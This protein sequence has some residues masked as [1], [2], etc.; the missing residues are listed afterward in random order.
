MERYECKGKWLKGQPIT[1]TI[2]DPKRERILIQCASGD[3]TVLDSK[4]N[5][6]NKIYQPSEETMLTAAAN[7]GHT[8]L[9][10]KILSRGA[11]VTP[12]QVSKLNRNAGDHKIRNTLRLVPM[13][14]GE[15]NQ[16]C[17][18][19]SP[20]TVK[21]LVQTNSGLV[22]K[23][24]RYGVP[25]LSVACAVGRFDVAKVLVEAFK[26]TND[27]TLKEFLEQKVCVR[28]SESELASL[29]DCDTPLHECAAYGHC[30]GLKWLLGCGVS[31]ACIDGRG[32]TA[33]HTAC[34]ND[35]LDVAACLIG[36]GV[37]P[38]M[39]DNDGDTPLHAAAAGGSLPCCSFLIRHCGV[40]PTHSGRPDGHTALH[41]S[42]FYG[43]KE[44]AF[45]LMNECGVDPQ[46][47]DAD[48]HTPFHEACFNGHLETAMLLFSVYEVDPHLTD[49]DGISPLNYA[50]RNG[51]MPVI[52]FLLEDAN[53][54]SRTHNTNLIYD[55]V[56]EGHFDVLQYLMEKYRNVA[57][58][59]VWVDS[60]AVHIACCQGKLQCLRYMLS[61]VVDA[62][63]PRVQVHTRIKALLNST[64]RLW[65]AEKSALGYAIEHG[66]KRL[67]QF[68]LEMGANSKNSSNIDNNNSSSSDEAGS[69]VTESCDGDLDVDGN[70]G[71]RVVIPHGA[72]SL[73]AQQ[74]ATSWGR[75]LWSK[76]LH[77][78]QPKAVR[79][80]VHTLFLI[81]CHPRYS[82]F[83]RALLFEIL[84]NLCGNDFGESTVAREFITGQIIE[85]K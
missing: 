75:L 29:D 20:E 39:V 28:E 24:N 48:G 72:K 68:L 1:R 76:Q 52:Q 11:V 57:D 9:V 33:L 51:H 62:N 22:T 63:H 7:A 43:Q 77:P 27:C 74:L 61:S 10:L 13:A 83:P 64:T 35:K 65:A 42:C 17:V 45:F 3:M 80:C 37:D 6:I 31:P 2:Y 34:T 40:D 85:L 8:E 41:Q 25:P 46:L 18:S 23:H 15:I 82:H 56:L 44:V 12:Q 30:E 14:E 55:A 73:T 79:Q 47:S 69:N 21:Q 50:I 70:Q 36:C 19:G 5:D 54:A 38:T 53:L 84:S 4:T 59:P 66:N 49:H 71:G 81:G 16:A 26:P 67:I 32:A 58:A 60:T 78:Y